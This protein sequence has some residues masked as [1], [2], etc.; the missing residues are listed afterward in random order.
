M[1]TVL[2]MA[3]AM[4]ASVAQAET[5]YKWTDQNGVTHYGSALPPAAE[6]QKARAAPV[7]TGITADPPSAPARG[8]TMAEQARIVGRING[9][10]RAQR[11]AARQRAAEDEAAEARQ[12]F[13]EAQA[14]ATAAEARREVRAQR[15]AEVAAR[16]QEPTI[17][18]GAAGGAFDQHGMYYQHGAGGSLTGSDGRVLMPSAGGY[19]DTRT[20]QFIPQ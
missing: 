20:G 14:R 19:V 10:Y 12:R 17:L 5:I 3:F 2:I 8:Y 1:K 13:V 15:R 9:E 6:Q 16:Q 4:L 11:D 18:Q 7:E